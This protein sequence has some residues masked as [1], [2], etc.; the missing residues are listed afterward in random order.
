MFPHGNIT[1]ETASSKNDG[2]GS[3]HFLH[4]IDSCSNARDSALRRHIKQIGFGVQ[5]CRHAMHARGLVKRND[6]VIPRS[7]QTGN[8]TARGETG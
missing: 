5:K 8:E 1:A 4:A 6:V 3:E 7:H 2:F